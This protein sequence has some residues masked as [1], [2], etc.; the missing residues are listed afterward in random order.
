MIAAPP[1]K[2][3]NAEATI[4]P[5]RIGTSSGTRVASWLWSVF[6]GSGRFGTG[7]HSPWRERGTRRRAARP[8]ASRSLGVVALRPHLFAFSSIRSAS[9]FIL[10][11][12]RPSPPSDSRFACRGAG[13]PSRRGDDLLEGEELVAGAG[14]G[15]AKGGLRLPKGGIQHSFERAVLAEKLRSGL[16]A[17]ALGAGEAIGGA[18]AAR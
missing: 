7:S 6:S 2:K 9:R 5:W 18:P 10:A 15:G 17:D 4:R 1:R 8:A 11:P 3:G 13:E 12:A 14:K 16:L